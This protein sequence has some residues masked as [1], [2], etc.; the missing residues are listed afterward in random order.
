[1]EPLKVGIVGPSLP[2]WP[3]ELIPK[4]KVKIRDI[5]IGMVGTTYSEAHARAVLAGEAEMIKPVIVSGHCSIGEE[6]PYC[7]TCGRWLK[8]NEEIFHKGHLIIY[9]Y[10]EGGVD[11]WAEIEAAKLGLKTEI[12][13][14]EVH[15]W[16][17]KV[18]EIPFA[19]HELLQHKA[20]LSK[21]EKRGYYFHQKLMQKGYRSRNIQIAEAFDIGFCVVPFDLFKVCKHHNVLGHP[22]NGGCWTIK[23]AKDKLDK[24]VHL[25][26]IK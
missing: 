6:L 15:Q 26:V 12:C 3:T 5:M 19:R 8:K 13:P 10:N 17:D 7:V 4:A 22:S 16:P 24:P 20:D 9:V 21:Y 25:V 11:T 14:A 18:S 2:K 23:Y 1:M